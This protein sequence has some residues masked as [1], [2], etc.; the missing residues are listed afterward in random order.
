[1]EAKAGWE[2]T[3]GLFYYLSTSAQ[4]IQKKQICGTAFPVSDAVRGEMTEALT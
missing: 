2:T 4:E 3:S 1:M